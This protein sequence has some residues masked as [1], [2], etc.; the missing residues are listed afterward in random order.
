MQTHGNTIPVTVW[1]QCSQV[2]VGV[3][4][5]IY[6]GNLCHALAVLYGYLMR[7]ANQNLI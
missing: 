6:K 7:P 5:Y 1:V 3:E 2:Q 4:K